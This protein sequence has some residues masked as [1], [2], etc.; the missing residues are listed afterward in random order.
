MKLEAIYGV[1]AV[2]EV[3]RVRPERV[4]KLLLLEGRP[5]NRRRDEIAA[6]ALRAGVACERASRAVLDREA[7]VDTHQGV[8]AWVVAGPALTLAE[9]LQCVRGRPAPALVF[10]DGVTDP[11]NLGAILRSAE[12]LGIQGV[13]VPKD[14]AAGLTPQARKA[15]AG[16][17]ERLALVVVT[18]LARALDEVRE[19]GFWV[20]GL[21][22][23]EGLPLHRY[24]WCRPMAVVLG[25]E[26]SGIRPGVGARCDEWVYI[27]QMG[28]IGSLNV[29]AAAAIV[30]YEIAKHRE[31]GGGQREEGGGDEEA[32]RP[33]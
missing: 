27:P 16:A 5:R 6:V 32:A 33:N 24:S 12:V 19:A 17:A 29:A 14:R 15:A 18:N 28:R 2:G 11:G 7:G 31:E 22:A 30:F 9:V 4:R 26:G 1:H 21:A 23:G 3:L 8:V 13:V 10:L 20:V 25:S